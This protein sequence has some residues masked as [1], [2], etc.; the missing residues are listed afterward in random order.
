MEK[1][2]QLQSILSEFNQLAN[3]NDHTG[4]ALLLAKTFGTQEEVDILSQIERDSDKRGHINSDELK[5]RDEISNK[6]Y[7]RLKRHL[8][9]NV[10]W[11]SFYDDSKKEL[12]ANSLSEYEKKYKSY[13]YQ[14]PHIQDILK[15]A[16]SYDDFMRLKKTF[17]SGGII[18]DYFENYDLLPQ[19]VSDVL[20]EYSDVFEEGDYSELEKVKSKLESIGFTFDYDLDG[21]AYALRPINTPLS[22]VMGFEDAEEFS[23]GG[24]TKDN[25]E[26]EVNKLCGEVVYDLINS[27]APVDKS[28]IIQ[29]EGKLVFV[30]KEELSTYQLESIQQAMSERK[31]CHHIIKPNA[32]LNYDENFKSIF[33]NLKMNLEDYEMF[34]KGGKLDEYPLEP[35]VISDWSFDKIYRSSKNYKRFGKYAMRT[36]VGYQIQ[37]IRT[38]NIKELEAIKSK[39]N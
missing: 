26:I 35:A 33:F 10:D 14:S 23:R 36:K 2:L 12:D 18:P 29:D 15:R 17:G 11:R 4:A 27:I 22:H 25:L 5:V 31:E 16:S 19:N 38:D 34:K 21:S 13:P 37:L 3:I 32:N 1:N 6:Y 28:F 8:D 24:V 7:Y 30:F 39:F 9:K 20:D